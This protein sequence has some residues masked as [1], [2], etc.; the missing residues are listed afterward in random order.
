MGL[1]TIINGPDGKYGLTEVVCDD[2]GVQAALGK[3]IKHQ[4]ECPSY[5][6]AAYCT[7]ADCKCKELHPPHRKRA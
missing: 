4:A 2:C 5:E 6:M 1:K 7:D 3:K